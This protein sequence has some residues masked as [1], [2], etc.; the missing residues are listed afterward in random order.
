MCKRCSSHVD[1]RDYDI[2]QTV[3]KNFRT[4]GRFIIQESGCLLNTDT[5]VHDAVLKGKVI[6]KI[7]AEGALEIHRTAEIKGTFKAGLLIIPAD[8]VF[9]WPE[10]I[11][12]RAAEIAGELQANVQ[13][14]GTV[15]LRT[16][17]RFFGN[18]EAGAM[19][20]ESGAIISGKLD[21]GPRPATISSQAAPATNRTPP[22]PEPRVVALSF[23]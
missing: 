10:T 17:A 4:K 13:A 1:L 22:V 7:T 15:I 19:R 12:L 23:R 8:T 6:G 11:V 3:S 21:L 9:R 5:V 2:T 18:I 20:V 16:G 14:S